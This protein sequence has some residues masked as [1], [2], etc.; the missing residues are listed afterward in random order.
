M[1]RQ[2]KRRL[3][4]KRLTKEELAIHDLV[5]PERDYWRPTSRGD[6]E[7]GHR[8]C[9][10]ILCRHHLYLSVDSIGSITF[11]F[12]GVEPWDIE[13]SCSLDVAD[14]GWHTLGEIGNVLGVTRERIRQI[15]SEASAKVKAVS[16]VR[17]IKEYVDEMAAE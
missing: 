2:P 13:E 15:E 9:P 17:Y 12:P 11:N 3:A 10:Y 4:I 6:C 7:N 14:D 5:Y 1:N 8:P 16:N